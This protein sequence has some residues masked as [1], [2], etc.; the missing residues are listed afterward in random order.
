MICKTEQKKIFIKSEG[1]Q[2]FYR[3]RES[4]DSL[5]CQNDKI[6]N[7]LKTLELSPKK[8][9][10]I[11][12]SN[13]SRLN[14]I[15]ATFNAKCQGIDPSCKAIED[16]EMKFPEIALN[17]G[18]A[19]CLSF[20]DNSFDTVILGFCLYLCDRKDLFKIAYEVDRCLM[21][22]GTL[23]IKDFSPP[24]PYKNKYLHYEN[25]F[26]YKMDY[27][28]MFKWNPAYTEIANLVFS[29]SGFKFR[30]IPNEKISIIVLRKN[31][32][33]AYLEEPYD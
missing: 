9:L 31:E 23:I 21:G 13:G 16:G 32:Q 28:K 26:S 24:F 20:A 33:Y 3:N 19:D 4:Y 6:I 11:G 15:Q 30:D 27:S 18:T 2:W 25:V 12:C 10:E 5:N 8:V 17:V 14:L 7:I 1:D 29:H 22:E